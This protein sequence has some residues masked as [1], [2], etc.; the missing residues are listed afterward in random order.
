LRLCRWAFDPTSWLHGMAAVARS[1]PHLPAQV[2]TSFA[3][4]Q[5]PAPRSEPCCALLAQ[6]NY[7]I[8]HASQQLTVTFVL[9]LRI[10]VASSGQHGML[11]D[12]AGWKQE[13]TAKDAAAKEAAASPQQSNQPATKQPAAAGIPGGF[14][15][16]SG[17]RTS[18]ASCR[19]RTCLPAIR[20]NDRLG[21][22]PPLHASPNPASHICTCILLW[23]AI[24]A[25]PYLWVICTNSANGTFVNGRP[26]MTLQ[27]DTGR[28]RHHELFGS[29]TLSNQDRGVL[30]HILGA[31]SPAARQSV[32]AFRPHFST[33][34]LSDNP[35]STVAEC[36]VPCMMFGHL[37]HFSLAQAARLLPPPAATALWPVQMS[38]RGTP[39]Y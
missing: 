9:P 1:S 2:R 18:H 8:E 17:T 14:G 39:L 36:R 3:T 7:S 27:G 37:A 4:G 15:V 23:A 28:W 20:P 6:T 32:S 21:F 26:R 25:P 29:T 22:S 34:G 12:A 11:Q 33:V 19:R 31:F 30:P 5:Q 16:S 10:D 13:G 35:G 38:K 24:L